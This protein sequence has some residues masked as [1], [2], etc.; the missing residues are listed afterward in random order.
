MDEFEVK[1]KLAELQEAL[2]SSAY[3]G[4]GYTSDAAR[5]DNVSPMDGNSIEDYFDQL[6]LQLKYVLFDLEA[7]R[8]ENRY[9]RQM[10]ETRPPAPPRDTGDFGGF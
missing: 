9:L 10:L 1:E 4:S 7:S 8:R 3:V 6:R 5:L 2:K